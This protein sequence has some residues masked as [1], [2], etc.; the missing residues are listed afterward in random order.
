M[1]AIETIAFK[2]KPAT[3]I[4]EFK[5]PSGR[6]HF[7]M[8]YFLKSTEGWQWRWIEE[9]TDPNWLQEKISE[10]LIFIFAE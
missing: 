4:E 10:G 6:R 8:H 5:L 2:V 1:I 9:G 3:S 7:N